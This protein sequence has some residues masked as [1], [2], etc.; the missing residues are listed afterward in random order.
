MRRVI[1]VLSVVVV[2]ALLLAPG[3]AAD[4]DGKSIYD[5]K[6]AMC[7]GKDGVAKKLAEGSANLNDPEWQEKSTLEEIIR[8]TTEG[9]NKMPAYEEKLTPE[10]IKL[11]AEY[12][13]TLQ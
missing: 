11:V 7:H 1:F 10:Q 13:K 3:L 9:V 2:G 5:K 4:E 6:C 12:I 8:V